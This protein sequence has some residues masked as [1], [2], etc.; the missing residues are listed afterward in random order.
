MYFGALCPKGAVCTRMANT[1]VPGMVF[2]VTAALLM[3]L[4]SVASG[5]NCI[6]AKSCG[7]IRRPCEFAGERR[8]VGGRQHERP[9]VCGRRRWIERERNFIGFGRRDRCVRAHHLH[10]RVLPLLIAIDFDDL[11]GNVP[12]DARIRRIDVVRPRATASSP[13]D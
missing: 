11:Q 3:Y 2:G 1:P 13:R 6:F 9:D 5:K 7:V 10:S 12:N 4:A 8:G